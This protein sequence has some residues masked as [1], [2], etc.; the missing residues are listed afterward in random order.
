VGCSQK[1]R[2]RKATAASVYA[3]LDLHEKSIQCVL[4]DADGKIV[5]ESKVGKDAERILEFLDGTQAS[6][7]ME[8]GYCRTKEDVSSPFVTGK[9]KDRVQFKRYHELPVPLSIPSP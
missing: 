9:R 8:S 7:V 4:K 5:R 1:I 3:A 2:R 6:V